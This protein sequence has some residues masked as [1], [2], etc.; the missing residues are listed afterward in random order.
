M[1]KLQSSAVTPSNRSLFEQLFLDLPHNKKRVSLIVA[2]AFLFI[3]IVALA[4]SIRQTSAVVIKPLHAINTA[5]DST[6][7]TT[8]KSQTTN[9][10]PTGADP[11]ATSTQNQVTVN[12]QNY[13]V[14]P[15]GSSHT[16]VSG[17]SGQTDVTISNSS[18]SQN[19]SGSSSSSNNLN[20]NVSSS[21]SSTS[22]STSN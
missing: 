20:V 10:A 9:K 15:N 1:Q 16:D 3:T 4:E 13:P 5:S 11:P 12:G 8:N 18:S 7:N 19:T 6:M 22:D 14:P 17:G 21:S 2:G